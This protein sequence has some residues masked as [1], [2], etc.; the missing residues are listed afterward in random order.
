MI[1]VQTN[2]AERNEVV[3]FRPDA[4]GRPERAAAVATGGRG[5]GEPHLPSQ[6]SVVLAGDRLLVANA[7]SDDVSLLD[8]GDLRLLEVAHAGSRPTSIAVHDDLVYVLANGDAVV[9]GFRLRDG[10]D[11][12]PGSTRPLSSPDADGAQVAFAPDGR[13]L[14]VTERGTN[15]ISIFPV[16]GDGLLDRPTT[17][18][19][20]GA[21]PY[22]F[23]FARGHLVVTEAFGGAVGRA[24]ASSYDDGLR[25]VSASLGTGRSEVCWA[26]ASPDGR[27]VWVTNFGDN[28]ISTYAVGAD[29]SLAVVDAVAGETH[30]GRKGLRDEALSGDGR[31]LYAL[32][33][34]ASELAAWRVGDGGK[35]EPVGATNGLPATA[36][37]LA[38]A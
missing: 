12:I 19:S 17:V 16:R 2:D 23:A 34:D 8:A 11:P 24:A 33:A 5:T 20:A 4:D 14:V 29:G 3:A 26:V 13:S 36:A 22:G 7:G 31:F 10:L 1:Y 28:T 21:T 25:P 9:T 38:A 27:F 15:A 32:D 35:L 30:P 6:G 37:G 18:P